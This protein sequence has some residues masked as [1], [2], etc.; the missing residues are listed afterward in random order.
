[1][2]DPESIIKVKMVCLSLLELR[3]PNNGKLLLYSANW[4]GQSLAPMT[5]IPRCHAC[6]CYTPWQKDFADVINVTT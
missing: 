4:D 1:M 5:F 3:N 2:I 6:Q